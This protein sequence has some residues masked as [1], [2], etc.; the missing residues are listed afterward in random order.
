MILS[1]IICDMN[2]YIKHDLYV[3]FHFYHNG[4]KIR[5]TNKVMAFVFKR[6]VLGFEVYLT[7]PNLVYHPYLTR[8]VCMGINFRRRNLTSADIRC[9]PTSVKS[10]SDYL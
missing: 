10:K 7:G 5:K 1:Y 8:T 9:W 4:K 2:K 3:F 6:F